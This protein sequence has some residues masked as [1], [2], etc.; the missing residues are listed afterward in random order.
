M[1]LIWLAV[2]AGA[3]VACGGGNPAGPDTDQ[4]PFDLSFDDPAG[5]TVPP[6]A[7]APPDLP[8]GIDLLTVGIA[9]GRDRVGLTLRFGEPVAPWSARAANSLDGFVDL[10]VDEQT[11][12]GVP[13]AAV[14]PGHNPQI[15]ADYYI[16]LRDARAGRVALVATRGRTFVL[17]PARFDGATVTI[18]IPRAELD[19]D[20]GE[21]RLSLVVGPP[22][23]PVTDYGPDD[24][25][26]V[27]H[28]PDQP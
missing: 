27:V 3:L 16:D 24:L 7:D 12:T 5:D 21:F 15:G 9:V 11:N 2:V 20:D 19:D 23:R 28:R 18:E 13:G 25:H 14:R 8:K 22:D 4:S 26:Y 1:R 6:V 10:D 17:V